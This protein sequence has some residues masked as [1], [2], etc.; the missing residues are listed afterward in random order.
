MEMSLNRCDRI[1]SLLLPFACARCAG[2][3]SRF[4]IVALICS[5]ANHGSQN[6]ARPTGLEC[7]ITSSANEFSGWYLGRV[8]WSVAEPSSRGGHPVGVRREDR[9]MGVRTAEG[10]TR[11]CCRSDFDRGSEAAGWHGTPPRQFRRTFVWRIIDETRFRGPDRRFGGR[12][13]TGHWGTCKPFPEPPTHGGMVCIAS[14]AGRDPARARVRDRLDLA[15]HSAR[16]RGL[17]AVEGGALDAPNGG[18]GGL[19]H[20]PDRNRRFFVGPVRTEAAG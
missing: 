3:R 17:P 13:G 8:A 15:R 18:P 14:K 4:P 9:A 11:W 6:A 5:S 2:R 1:P 16:I 10:V 7:A 12:F 19:E 20:E